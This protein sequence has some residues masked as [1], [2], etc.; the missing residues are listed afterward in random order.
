MMHSETSRQRQGREAH[1]VPRGQAPNSSMS[2]HERLP[3]GQGDLSDPTAIGNTLRGKMHGLRGALRQVGAAEAKPGDEE[4]DEGGGTAAL[5]AGHHEASHRR[6]SSLGGGLKAGLDAVFAEVEM[7]RRVEATLK[8]KLQEDRLRHQHQEVSH[9]SPDWHCCWAALS[10][11]AVAR[12]ETASV[13]TKRRQP[14]HFNCR[15]AG[16]GDRTRHR[17]GATCCTKDRRGHGI[18][19]TCSSAGGLDGWRGGAQQAGSSLNITFF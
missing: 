2:S 6:K 14:W 9:D 1:L 8:V 12:S 13:L 4:A 10:S 19:E 5:A 17:G 18:R 16:A 15:F 7:K 11:L 3:A